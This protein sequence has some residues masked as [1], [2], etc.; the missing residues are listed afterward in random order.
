MRLPNNPDANDDY[1]EQC[2][3]VSLATL[4]TPIGDNEV[5]ESVRHNGVYFE[6]K[7][8][9]QADDPSLPLGVWSHELKTADW[10]KVKKLA[11]AALCGKS[12]DLQLAVWLFEANIHL[13]GFAGIAPAALLIEE[14]CE[15]YWDNMHPQMVDGDIEF[16]TNPISWV[17]DKLTPQLKMITL[18]EAKFD[19][20]EYCWYDWEN[21]LRQEQL[22][23][24]N[25]VIGEYEGPTPNLFKKRLSATPDE[26]ILTLFYDLYDGGK[27]LER[28]QQWF[29]GR[30]GRDSPNLIDLSGLLSK[31]K[32]M[33]LAELQRRK[34]DFSDTGQNEEN[35]S[36]MGEDSN[37]SDN[38]SDA[39]SNQND[40][41]QNNGDDGGSGGRRYAKGEFYDRN[42]VF[43]CLKKAA[44]FLKRD[45]PH[46]PVPYLVD[47]ACDWGEKD[48]R[49][50]YQ[51]LFLNLGGQLN[52]FELMGLQQEQGQTQE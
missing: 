40:D 34:I 45:D 42:D 52:I 39:N 32:E 50:L 15:Q 7:E 16:R 19:G 10:R 18:T 6:I 37:Q 49:E 17:N 14:L 5:G 27:A 33:I 12:K 51:E 48:A 47:A 43:V 46:S 28:L 20:K 2:F 22:K 1:I 3:G 24:Q 13:S 29:D 21:A 38:N 44:E 25:K 11:L 35:V 8:A 9:R 36:A 30:C 23:N 41:A 31:I 4:L 26:I